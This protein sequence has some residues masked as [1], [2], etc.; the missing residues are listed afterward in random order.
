MW[1]IEDRQMELLLYLLMIIWLIKSLNMELW[2]IQRF[3]TLNI[4]ILV[5][6]G[7]QITIKATMKDDFN[8]IPLTGTN[9]S[10]VKKKLNWK[11]LKEILIFFKWA[12]QITIFRYTSAWKKIVDEWRHLEPWRW[13]HMEA[14]SICFIWE[15]FQPQR[16]SNEETV[17]I[18]LISAHSTIVAKIICIL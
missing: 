6:R 5:C 16:S 11:Q 1:C 7:G 4:F 13:W 10:I 14:D 2:V 15:R 17:A 3:K 18:L 8:G 9:A 12:K